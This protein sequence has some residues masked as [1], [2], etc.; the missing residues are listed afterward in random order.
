MSGF[1]R[2]PTVST[3]RLATLMPCSA[4][5]WLELG[6]SCTLELLELVVAWSGLRLATSVWPP[7]LAT[8]VWPPSLATLEWGMSGSSSSTWGQR[9]RPCVSKA[10]YSVQN[11]SNGL[12]F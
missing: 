3:C 11:S 5:A 1:M 6:S 7:S 4:R 9:I 8:S 12:N 10:D 2:T